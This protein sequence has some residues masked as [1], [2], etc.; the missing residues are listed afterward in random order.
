[1]LKQNL[2]IDSS[3]F[4]ID[5]KRKAVAIVISHNSRNL[6]MNCSVVGDSFII[7][8]LH[9]EILLSE[10]SRNAALR[11]LNQR[12]FVVN[13]IRY[14]GNV[15]VSDS[16]FDEVHVY[17]CDLKSYNMASNSIVISSEDLSGLI[18]NELIDDDMTRLVFYRFINYIGI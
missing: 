17:Y 13:G 12:G 5:A 3:K 15:F 14:L 16:V 7:T 6:I 4:K 10:S 1:M 18:Y 8:F 11:L 9:D 2:Y